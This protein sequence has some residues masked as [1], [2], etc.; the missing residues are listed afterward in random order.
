MAALKESVDGLYVPYS[1]TIPGISFSSTRDLC[2]VFGNRL[3]AKRLTIDNPQLADNVLPGAGLLPAGC[4]IA[5]AGAT[6]DFGMA[7]GRV[8][9][10]N[11]DSIT[12]SRID[13][14]LIVALE[15]SEPPDGATVWFNGRQYMLSDNPEE[16][17]C[18][19]IEIANPRAVQIDEWVRVYLR[20]GGIR[21]G[22]FSIL[23]QNIN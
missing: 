20:G 9:I 2:G 1:K 10:C 22:G 8:R 16:M 15:E 13:E 5:Y 21:K 14:Q 18:S 11:T 4:H 3:F 12:C 23:E 7:F 19:E 6:V 17:F